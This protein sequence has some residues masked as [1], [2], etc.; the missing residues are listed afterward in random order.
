VTFF[1]EIRHVFH[2]NGSSESTRFPKELV[3]GNWVKTSHPRNFGGFISLTNSEKWAIKNRVE[4]S[5][6]NSR[7]RKFCAKYEGKGFH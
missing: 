4:C 7:I 5:F 1:T 3:L 6:H 2:G